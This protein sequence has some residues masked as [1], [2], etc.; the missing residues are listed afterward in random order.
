MSKVFAFYL[1]DDEGLT[2]IQEPGHVS[3]SPISLYPFSSIDHI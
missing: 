3:K 1:A 2:P